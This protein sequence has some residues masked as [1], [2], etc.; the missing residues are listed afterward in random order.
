MNVP[1]YTTAPSAA[2]A[3]PAVRVQQLCKQFTGV[4]VLQDISF[5][6]A[7]G[8]VHSIIGPNGA[9]KTTLLNVLSGLYLPS[10][11][12]VLLQ[13]RDI[14][15]L[16]PHQLAAQGLSRT[17]QNLKIAFNLSAL[18]NV[19][20][21][22]HLQLQR[23]LWAGILGAPRLRRQDDEAR[24]LAVELLDFV[25]V[26]SGADLMPGALSFGALK[27]LEIAR[28]LMSQPQVLLLD[29]PA[30]GLNPQET[31]DIQRLLQRLAQQALT[32]VLVEHDMK[33]V[34]SVSHNVV[35]INYGMKIAEGTPAHVSHHP[36]VV[37]AYLG[38]HAA[39]EN[40]A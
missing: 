27:R 34:M 33:L 19:M 15:G 24:A 17:F 4:P 1:G 28:A 40:G 13:G 30:A 25:G 9:G 11:G 26:P 39:V 23:G 37:A 16:Q 32:V 20:L 6:L 29:E 2:A 7:R 38:S 35:V 14:A 22:R 21:G 3:E 5:D 8:Q 36:E 31:Q 18:E 10:S 12:R